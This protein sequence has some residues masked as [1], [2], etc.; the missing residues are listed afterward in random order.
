MPP[1]ELI[2]RLQRR[3]EESAQIEQQWSPKQSVDS[4]PP[5]R[6]PA[7][8]AA[9][10]RDED[11]VENQLEQADPNAPSAACDQDV[12]LEV[13]WDGLNDPGN[14]K[15]PN[16][17]S[18]S[19]KWVIVL[20]GSS[21]S[22]CVTSASAMYTSIYE[23]FEPEFGATQLQM[24]AGL[25]LFIWGL[26]FG[27]LLFSPLSE[28]YGRKPIYVCSLGFSWSGSCPALWRRA[29]PPCLCPVSSTQ[30]PA[31]RSLVWLGGRWATFFLR[32]S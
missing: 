8:G 21:A 14:P 20:V 22:M 23:Q 24:T 6:P 11:T 19:Q 12:V 5:Q 13:Q 1:K 18:L 9:F 32:T 29:L 17:A 3:T 27:P 30:W 26:G 2:T 4:M 16:F 10:A 7:H 28:F 25:S 15:G 31:A